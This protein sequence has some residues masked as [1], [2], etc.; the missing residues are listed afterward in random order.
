MCWL[1]LGLKALAL[2]WLQALENHQPSH[3]ERLRLGSGQ[4]WPK[5]GLVVS[6]R[7]GQERVAR[8]RSELEF[9]VTHTTHLNIS[10]CVHTLRRL[11]DRWAAAV[12]GE[13]VGW[14]EKG[15]WLLCSSS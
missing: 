12:G 6:G 1:G 7:D 13:R 3:R 2:A 10:H 14:V 8:G 5:P 15:A 9:V 11:A 4:L